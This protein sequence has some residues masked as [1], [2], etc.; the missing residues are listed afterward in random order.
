MA[1]RFLNKQPCCFLWLQ[2]GLC[3]PLALR[4]HITDVVILFVDSGN[5]A[6]VLSFRF[7]SN[8]LFVFAVDGYQLHCPCKI[9]YGMRLLY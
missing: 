8:R 5:T 2:F 6:L 9:I 3:L 4:V 7:C 1:R